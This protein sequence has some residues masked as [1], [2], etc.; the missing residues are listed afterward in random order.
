MEKIYLSLDPLHA[1]AHGCAGD[2]HAPLEGRSI[3]RV[4][5]SQDSLLAVGDLVFHRNGWR[6]HALVRPEVFE[7]CY[8]CWGSR[9]F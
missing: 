9:N 3:G 6:M 4:V 5:D 7:S 2:L 1:R 8:R